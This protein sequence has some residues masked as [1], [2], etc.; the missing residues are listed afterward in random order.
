MSIKANFDDVLNVVKGL[1]TKPKATWDDLDNLQRTGVIAAGA[2]PVGLG[3]GLTMMGG[4][5]A[6]Q[7]MP[8]MPPQVPQP[9]PVSQNG[10]QM[11]PVMQQPTPQRNAGTGISMPQTGGYNLPA[12]MQ[13]VTP[14]NAEEISRAR[15]YANRNINE[16]LITLAQLT[17]LQ[18]QLE[19]Q[20]NG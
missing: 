3:L 6:P 12:L 1:V 13:N 19:G 14:L 10:Q 11:Q 15:D 7:P 2:A 8:M 5:N 20:Q 18:E 16:K 17:A 4:N 9:V